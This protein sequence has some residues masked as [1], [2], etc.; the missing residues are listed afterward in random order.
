MGA[1]QGER[2]LSLRG[3]GFDEREDRLELRGQTEAA[4]CVSLDDAAGLRALRG[5]GGVLHGR[6]RQRRVGRALDLAQALEALGELALR[7]GLREE[8]ALGGG[9]D[10]L[11]YGLQ[12]AAV[13]GVD[14]AGRDGVGAEQGAEVELCG[15]RGRGDGEGQGGRSGGDGGAKL[16]E[17]SLQR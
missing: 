12:R 3:Q 11:E 7:G 8:L 5:L 4:R 1:R 13:D 14:D 17:N 10:A 9:V 6:K 15:G 16:R 2:S